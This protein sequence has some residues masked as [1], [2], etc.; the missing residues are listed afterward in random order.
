M[1]NGRYPSLSSHIDSIAE[2]M[3][4]SS[5][6]SRADEMNRLLD[7]A[8]EALVAVLAL[9]RKL[10]VTT[11]DDHYTM[12]VLNSMLRDA[13]GKR[14]VYDTLDVKNTPIDVNN[15]DSANAAMLAFA[16]QHGV[17]EQTAVRF[18]RIKAK[19]NGFEP[20]VNI[21]CNHPRC[22]EAKA[23]SFKT[24]KEMIEAEKRAAH[25]I[26]YCHH[27]R[28]A[29]LLN[30]QAL[31]DEFLDVLGHIARSPGCNLKESGVK[32][33]DIEFLGDYGLIRV[34]R[35]TLGDRVLCFHLFITDEGRRLL[36]N[37]EL[38]AANQVRA[39]DE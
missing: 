38:A 7:C 16:E 27:H 14:V 5:V 33:K 21:K 1:T 19:A 15:L 17:S 4:F 6:S 31:S 2:N 3:D 26:W 24:P 29:A 37:R 8:C 32:R 13:D 28:E 18:N 34:E 35:T 39:N 12:I 10:N 20:S 25:G 23:I 9:S 11:L 22:S 30:E 36:S